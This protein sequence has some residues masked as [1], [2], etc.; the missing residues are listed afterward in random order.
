MDTRAGLQKGL[1]PLQWTLAPLLY[2]FFH[3]C[4]CEKAS[5]ARP[6]APSVGSGQSGPSQSSFV[7]SRSASVPRGGCRLATRHPWQ[8]ASLPG[9]RF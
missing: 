2:A 3:T 9:R 6:Y 8:V 1:T 4:G 5:V 7:L